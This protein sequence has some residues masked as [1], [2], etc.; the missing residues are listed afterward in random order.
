MPPLSPSSTARPPDRRYWSSAAVRAARWRPASMPVECL[1]LENVSSVE[2]VFA[3]N[4]LTTHLTDARAGLDL[5]AVLIPAT[6]LLVP[7]H[8]RLGAACPAAHRQPDHAARHSR[9]REKRRH[10]PDPAAAPTRI[11][12]AGAPA[13]LPAWP[14]NDADAAS[15]LR[16]RVAPDCSPACCWPAGPSTWRSIPARGHGTCVQ[17]TAA[18]RGMRQ[19]PC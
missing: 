11:A 7:R 19:W 3:S 18:W 1:L 5:S 9:W 12:A 8:A 13:L 16:G 17:F 6:E 4:G 14:Q 2:S 10:L 15:D